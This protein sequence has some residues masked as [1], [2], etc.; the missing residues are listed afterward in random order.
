MRAKRLLGVLPDGLALP[1]RLTGGELL[2]Y[3]GLLR[4]LDADVVRARAAD[5]LQVPE[6][7]AADAAGVLVAEYSTGM[8]R[9]I[10]LATALLLADGLTNAEIAARLH[11]SVSSVKATISGALTRLDL[12][13]RVQL[14]ILAHEARPPGPAGGAAS[15]R[16]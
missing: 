9:K 11:L 5:L 3:R 10:G 7:D 12:G 2:T 8:R 4:E 14:A 13:D 1:E 16:R 6:L 15:D